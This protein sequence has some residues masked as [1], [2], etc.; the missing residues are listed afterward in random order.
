M[1][2]PTACEKRNVPVRFVSITLFH[3]SSRISSTGAPQ[4]VPALLIKMSIR[5]KLETVAST[6]AFTWSGILTSQPRANVFTPSCFNSSA[7]RSQR[8]FFRAHSTTFAPISAKPSAIWRPSPTEPPV[9]IATRPL[10][11]SSFLIFIRNFWPKPASLLESAFHVRGRL[12][13]SRPTAR[14]LSTFGDVQDFAV[15][16]ELLKARAMLEVR[17]AWTVPPAR[18][19]VAD[20]T[21]QICSDVIQRRST[22]TNGSPHRNPNLHSPV[23]A[24]NGRRY[25]LGSNSIY[26]GGTCI[27]LSPIID[28]C[29]PGNIDR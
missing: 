10:R 28:S 24:S 13:P 21:R 9:M 14:H 8:S 25:W 22:W 23:S 29:V 27:Q 20:V 5:P 19:F 26:A 11:S 7:A 16:P 1:T 15:F 6:T 3:C 18:T 2:L 12:A 4:D 17:T